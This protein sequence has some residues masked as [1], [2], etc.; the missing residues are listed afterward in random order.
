VHWAS[1][2]VEGDRFLGGLVDAHAVDFAIPGEEVDTKVTAEQFG[3][4]LSDTLHITGGGIPLG[5]HFTSNFPEGF[6]R[7]TFFDGRSMPSF[8]DYDGRVHLCWQA[9]QNES[10]GTQAARLYY[11]RQRVNLGAVG[12][13][14]RLAPNC[15]V[16]AFETMA[17]KQLIGQCS[18]GYGCLRSLELLYATRLSDQIRPMSGSGNGIRQ[19]DG[20]PL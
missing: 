15:R 13:D 6:P 14:G 12:G 20:T 3:A 19:K 1:R 16:Y 5:A 4:I 18:E 7:D 9:N 11:A 2:P 10:A 8:A 17:S